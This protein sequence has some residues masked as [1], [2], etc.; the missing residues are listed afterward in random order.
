MDTGDEHE[1]HAR[2]VAEAVRPH[3]AA[4]PSIQLWLDEHDSRP[5][6]SSMDLHPLPTLAA[7]LLALHN[8]PPRL[9]AHLTLVH[10]VAVRLLA[11]LSKRFTTLTV[12]HA[13]VAFGA[14]THDIGKAFVVQELTG[15]GHSHEQRGEALMLTWNVPAHMA[16]F[17][18]THGLPPD[19]TDLT[20]EDLLVQAA[21]TAWKGKRSEAL[22]TALAKAIAAATG[23][24]AWEAFGVVDD[25]LTALAEDADDRLEHQ[26]RFSVTT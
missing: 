3:A 7:E 11:K 25:V 16:R 21:D 19:S 26:A 2:S 10:D 12:D 5:A 1:H 8:A 4:D 6:R 22:D 14:A 9:T 13:A 24:A 20:L 17:A 18:R 15:T 23:T